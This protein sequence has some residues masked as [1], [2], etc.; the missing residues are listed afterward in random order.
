MEREVSR[1]LAV[2]GRRAERFVL[3]HAAVSGPLGWDDA[4]ME[5]KSAADFT[6]PE[7]ET[8]LLSLE[9]KR[10]LIRDDVY[11]F[12]ATQA[13]AF[14]RD[15]VRETVY[16]GVPEGERRTS[17]VE[18]AHWL[19]ANEYDARFSAWFPIEAMIARQKSSTASDSTMETRQSDSAMRSPPGVLV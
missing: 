7:I 11:S 6:A 17:H 19:V 3:R 10:Y 5:A 2:D 15:T 12:A 16:R 4:L 1:L 13:Y 8:A 9:M 14:R 18:V